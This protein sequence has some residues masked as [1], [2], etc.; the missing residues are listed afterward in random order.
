MGDIFQDPPWM[1]GT[2]YSTEPYIYYDLPIHTHLSSLRSCWPEVGLAGLAHPRLALPVSLIP[3]LRA[4]H[5]GS[6][7]PAGMCTTTLHHCGCC[8]SSGPKMELNK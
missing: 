3:D 1:P 7:F 8:T 2:V 4:S 6:F 5:H